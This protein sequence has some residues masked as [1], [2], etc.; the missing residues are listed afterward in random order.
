MTIRVEGAEQTAASLRAC[1]RA[2][3]RRIR[4][5]VYKAGAFM[6]TQVRANAT[7][8]HHRPGEPH[9]PGTGPG[10]NVAT[11]DY[12][13]TISME[14]G[15]ALGIAT[16]TVYTNDPR[17]ARLE[18][19]FVGADVLGRVYAQPAYPHWAPAIPPT[20]AFLAAR[21]AADLEAADAETG[22]RPAPGVGTSISGTRYS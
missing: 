3:E 17:A 4:A 1:G 7:T 18:N 8:G 11:G 6:R 12:R 2:T 5:S 13:R 22:G 14:P 15:H 21:I 20:E 9:I 10:P 16:A 19:G